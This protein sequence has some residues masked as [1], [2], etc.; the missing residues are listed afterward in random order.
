M[1]GIFRF[2]RSFGKEKLNNVGQSITQ[3]IVAWDPETASQAEIED[4][5]RELDKITIEAGKAKADYDREQAEADAANK[6]YDKYVAAAELLNK[7]LQEAQT[8]GD[9]A[10]ASG[11]SASLDK[12]LHELE[13]MQPEVDREVREAGEAKAYYEEIRSLAEVT[14]Q[15]VRTARTQLE[16]A[17]R[18]MRR[19]EIERQRAESRSEKAEYTAGLRKETSSLGVALEAMNR[20]A[21]QAR[22]AAA[23][24]DMK[25]K[26]LGPEPP[27]RD[28]HI[29]EALKT[30][31]AEQSAAPS[32][33]A[34][35]LAALRKN[36]D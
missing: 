27:A 29:E 5:I 30:V 14:A 22:A 8:G 19:A 24:S 11:I 20:Q 18:D 6:N 4:M 23:A 2:L 16:Q 21:E 26:L 25:S 10:K 28:Q 36:Q 35:R 17:Q 9:Q 31:S 15:K 32:S 34:D 1:A 33:F 13:Q 7:Q 12:L 3:K